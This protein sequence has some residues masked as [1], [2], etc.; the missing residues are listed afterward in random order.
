[1]DFYETRKYLFGNSRVMLAYYAEQTERLCHTLLAD[2]TRQSVGYHT[3]VF[4]IISKAISE[5]L[6]Q[7]NGFSGT[8]TA[9]CRIE[10]DGC[11]GYTEV[12]KIIPSISCESEPYAYTPQVKDCDRTITLTCDNISGLIRI[13]ANFGVK[14]NGC[15]D[16][17]IPLFAWYPGEYAIG[18][19]PFNLYEF[20]VPTN[21][22]SSVDSSYEAIGMERFEEYYT[23]AYKYLGGKTFDFLDDTRY[24]FLK[25]IN[26]A[27]REYNE[28]LAKVVGNKDCLLDDM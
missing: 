18:M 23:K 17:V 26:S 20:G 8:K 1:M 15:Y 7:S 27:V 5:F 4:R 9:S 12:H 19:T 2:C 21:K 10:T 25:L 3:K 24:N 13:Y 14:E 16:V 22:K 11:D 6:G 28:T